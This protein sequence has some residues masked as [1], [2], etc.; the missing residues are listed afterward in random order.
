M[1]ANNDN[2]QNRRN[3]NFYMITHPSRVY[4]PSYN[5]LTEIGTEF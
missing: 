1:N 2:T 3:A 5:W 4:L